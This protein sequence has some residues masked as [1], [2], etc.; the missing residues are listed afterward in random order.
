MGGDNLKR[1]T[2]GGILTMTGAYYVDIVFT[3]ASTYLH[4][5]PLKVDCSD[6][7]ITRTSSSWMGFC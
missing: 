6:H 3:I 4:C 2:H 1:F 7:L 5:T